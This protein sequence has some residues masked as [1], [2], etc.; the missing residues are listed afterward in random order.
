MEEEEHSNR[1]S[2]VP[3]MLKYLIFITWL[4]SSNV[5]FFSFDI[6]SNV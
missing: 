1:N 5:V 3:L 6:V 2:F 4:M